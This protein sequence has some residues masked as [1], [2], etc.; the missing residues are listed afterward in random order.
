MM[1]SDLDALLAPGSLPAL[2]Q[3]IIDGVL[4]R[5][6]ERPVVGFGPQLAVGGVA[7][8]ASCAASAAGVAAA[9]GSTVTAGRRRRGRALGA[10]VRVTA[11][12]LATAFFAA[13]FTVRLALFFTLGR[14]TFRAATLAVAFVGF[15]VCLALPDFAL[16][17]FFA[18]RA[19][20]TLATRAFVGVVLRACFQA[21]RP[22]QHACV[23]DALRAWHP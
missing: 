2:F 7:G 12:G 11:A 6:A 17:V 21:L 5:W 13:G 16:A 10:G 23:R 19:A 4:R 22:R 18:L 3:P 9:V 15:K 20:P 8:T 1:V 14:V